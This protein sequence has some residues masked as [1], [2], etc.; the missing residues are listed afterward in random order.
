MYTNT[1]NFS[2]AALVHIFFGM[3]QPNKT[4]GQ[5]VVV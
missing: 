4:M 3:E 1:V 2:K 5:L